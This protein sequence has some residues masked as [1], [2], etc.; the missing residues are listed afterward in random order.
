MLLSD[1]L[2]LHKGDYYITNLYS[3]ASSIV[4]N[5]LPC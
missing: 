3:N 4:L 1:I 5:F 2:I